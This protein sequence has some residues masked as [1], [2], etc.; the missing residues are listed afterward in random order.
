MVLCRECYDGADDGCR[1]HSEGKTAEAAVERWNDEQA[2][3]LEETV[4]PCAYCGEEAPELSVG[5]D[6]SYV[7]CCGCGA[8]GPI[9]GDDGQ[10]L[11]TRQAVDAWNSVH[12]GK[13]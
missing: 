12:R 13:S 6:L 5:S 7:H 11:A 2:E 4:A 3:R 1:E 8:D 9:R 10:P